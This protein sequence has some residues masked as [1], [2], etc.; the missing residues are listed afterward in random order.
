MFKGNTFKVNGGF[1]SVLAEAVGNPVTS[2]NESLLPPQPTRKEVE[3]VLKK[4]GA[5]K[6]NAKEKASFGRFSDLVIETSKLVSAKGVL[7]LS[8]GSLKFMDSI[9]IRDVNSFYK[10]SEGNIDTYMPAMNTS[11]LGKVTWFTGFD[12]TRLK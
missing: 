5:K 11:E 4:L 2:I 10:D 1:G 3:S 9:T 7:F 6:P 12:L 8:D